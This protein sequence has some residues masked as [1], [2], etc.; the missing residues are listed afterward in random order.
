MIWTSLHDEF[1]L[2]EAILVQPYLYK[3]GSREK[4]AAWTRIAE[5]L[6]SMEQ[7]KFYVNQ[8][9]VRERFNLIHTRYVSMISEELKRSGIAPPPNTPCESLLEDISSRIKDFEAKCVLEKEEKQADQ[10]KIQ[11]VR[12]KALETLSETKKRKAE[13]DSDSEKKN[14]RRRHRAAPTFQFLTEKVKNDHLFKM[15][16]MEM[17]KQQQEQQH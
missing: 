17:Q 12:L 15:Q 2:R 5:S 6:S 9:S 3:L 1:L 4:G 8:R 7:P 13:E 14:A 16:Q 11:D 10:K